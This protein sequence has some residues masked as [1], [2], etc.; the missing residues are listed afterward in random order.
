MNIR[1][2]S[3][4][5][6]L[7]SLSVAGC[8]TTKNPSGEIFVA[9][10][11]TKN[12]QASSVPTDSGILVPAT[13]EGEWQRLGPAIQMISSATADPQDP[14]TIFLACG[15]G[16]V[17]TKDGGN[18]WRM[19][20]GWRES[21]AL[22]IAIDPE[23]S[24][25]IYA[26]TAWGVI[27]S[28]DGGDSWKASNSGLA[29]NFAKG[30]VIDHRDN[31]RLLLANTRGLYESD[32]RGLDWRRVPGIPEVAVLRLRRGQSQPDLWIAGTEGNGVYVSRDDGRTWEAVADALNTANVYAV[33]IDPFSGSRMAA[34][35]WG[36]GVH[37]SKDGGSS[38]QAVEGA[39]PSPN[40][41]AMVF[42]EMIA[43][44]LWISTF[45]EGTFFSDDMGQ[46]WQTAN[47]DGAY[48]FDLGFLPVRD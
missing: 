24:Y 14:N 12:Q 32:N 4:I 6:L 47:L 15:N 48:V 17:R 40:V 39:L 19:V 9:M 2:I 20:T 8:S 28:S 43:G 18:T 16:I 27:V 26:A 30:I 35:G 41:T 25:R 1:R 31:N 11:M 33:A 21:D 10:I 22:Q 37:V 3:A 34:G 29:E 23:D 45:E 5:G 46:S 13:T 36:T 7:V 42:D 38:W 44:R